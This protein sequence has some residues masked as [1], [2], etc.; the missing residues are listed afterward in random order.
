ML[1]SSL[2]DLRFFGYCTKFPQNP[3]VQVEFQ[4]EELY[5]LQA[6]AAGWKEN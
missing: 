4:A 3:V 5:F 2:N 1:S 6:I